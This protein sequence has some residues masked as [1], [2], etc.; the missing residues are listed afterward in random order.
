MIPGEKPSLAGL[1]REQVD[2][3]IDD[4]LEGTPQD[5]VGQ[6]LEEAMGLPK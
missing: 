4:A 5:E 6:L 3:E 2:K 1:T